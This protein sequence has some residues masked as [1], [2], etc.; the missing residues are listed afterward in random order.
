MRR[1]LIVLTNIFLLGGMAM[2][3]EVTTEIKVKGMTCGSC[4]VSVK[5]ALTQTKGVK[6]AEVS[7][8]KA[9]ATVVYEDTQVNEQQLRDAINKTGFEAQAKEA[10]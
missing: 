3:K 7:L 8:E 6:S 4:V 10:K 1:T 2:A 5:K 9:Q